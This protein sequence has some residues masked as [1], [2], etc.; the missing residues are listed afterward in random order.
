MWAG[1]ACVP[2]NI[3]FTTFVLGSKNDLYQKVSRQ[4]TRT[5]QFW[6]NSCIIRLQRTIRQWWIILANLRIKFIHSLRLHCIVKPAYT[7]RCHSM[8]RIC[9]P[10]PSLPSHKHTNHS[11]FL[12]SFLRYAKPTVPDIFWASNN[13]QTCLKTAIFLSLSHSST[14][15]MAIK[16]QQSPSY[17]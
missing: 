16:Q 4:F 17:E 10:P 13:W 14:G 2:W 11:F 12:P 15:S 9:H 7:S 5:R 3:L 8:K 6:T 1:H